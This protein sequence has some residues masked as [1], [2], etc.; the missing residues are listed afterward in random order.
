VEAQFDNGPDFRIDIRLHTD[1]P[2]SAGE[3]AVVPMAVQ[4]ESLMDVLGE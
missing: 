4:R 1:N 2:T 3:T